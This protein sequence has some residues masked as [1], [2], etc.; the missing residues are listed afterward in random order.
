MYAIV[1]VSC[2]QIRRAFNANRER[3]NRARNRRRVKTV[4]PVTFRPVLVSLSVSRARAVDT[5]LK[6]QPNVRAVHRVKYRVMRDDRAV[7]RAEP[8]TRQ[9][10][11]RSPLEVLAVSPAYRDRMRPVSE[12]QTARYVV[13]TH[14]H[15]TEILRTA[16]NAN[17]PNSLERW[18]RPNVPDVMQAV[19]VSFACVSRRFAC[20]MQ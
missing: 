20:N 12:M 3:S 17:R 19:C 10:R 9:V 11:V 6:V 18:A 14:L 5:P 16:P 8:V 15:P 7:S 1:L 2:D 4:Q 13:S